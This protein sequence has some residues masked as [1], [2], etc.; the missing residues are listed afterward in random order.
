MSYKFGLMLSMLFVLMFFTLGVDII[1]VQFVMSDL[2]AKSIAISYIISEHGKLDKRTIIKI[3]S[4]YQVEFT[5]LD[6][7]NPQFGD[8]VNYK[9]SREIT[10]IVINR[11]PMEVSIV[12]SAVIGYFA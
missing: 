11:G 2:D 1:N 9:I 5:C 6:N 8:V 12:R 3:E 7:C 10:P 4:T